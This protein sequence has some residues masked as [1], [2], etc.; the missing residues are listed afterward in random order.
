MNLKND[1]LFNEWLK[2]LEETMKLVFNT[3][4]IKTHDSLKSLLHEAY[5]KGF[6]NGKLTMKI[7]FKKKP[8]SNRGRHGIY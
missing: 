5:K 4:N 3:E 6:D 8:I 2:D 7:A 1:K